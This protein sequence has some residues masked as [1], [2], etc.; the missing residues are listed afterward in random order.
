[1]TKRND[2][3]TVKAD[4]LVG[5]KFT[6]R[7]TVLAD[8]NPAIKAAN[9][10]TD[11]ITMYDVIGEDWWTGGGVT[12]KRIDAALR[13]IGPK[14]VIVNINSPGGDF[15][16]GVAIYNMLKNHPGAVTVRIMGLAASAASVIAMAGDDIE[17]AETGFLMVH[18]AWV[19]AIGNRHDMQDAADTLAPFDEAMADLYAKRSGE[20]VETATAWMDGSGN[21]DGT[22]FNGKS[23]VEVGLADSFLPG[24]LIDEDDGDDAKA[25]AGEVR[26]SR[27][28]ENALRAQNPD[29]SRREGRALLAEHKGGGTS[30][31]T[32][33]DRAMPDASALTGALEKLSANL[34][35]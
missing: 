28:I 20:T 25:L 26:A 27:R 18:N 23:A 15:F 12:S 16:E 7:D 11:T 34:T 21:S 6:A 9:D 10:T 30:R 2:L 13:S 31:A 32:P 29:L 19:I 8:W 3:P 14:D 5:Q 4:A 24:D 1:M 22:W 33:P 35:T 17:I